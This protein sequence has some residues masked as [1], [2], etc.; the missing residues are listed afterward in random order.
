M[1]VRGFKEGME[2]VSDVVGGH[3]LAVPLQK[4]GLGFS[5]VCFLE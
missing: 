1:L 4:R 5:L 3:P 2:D